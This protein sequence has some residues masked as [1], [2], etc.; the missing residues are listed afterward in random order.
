MSSLTEEAGS[1]ARCPRTRNSEL[2]GFPPISMRSHVKAASGGAWK[3]GNID[4]TGADAENDVALEFSTPC[5][6]STEN[7]TVSRHLLSW[8]SDR[9]NHS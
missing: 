7:G 8:Q 6:V 5:H 4:F 1:W 9:K 3:E 2:N